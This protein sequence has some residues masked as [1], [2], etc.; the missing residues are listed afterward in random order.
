MIDVAQF[1]IDYPYFA[2][3]TKFPDVTLEGYWDIA[4]LY[5][6]DED[7]GYLTGRYRER[8]VSLMT[9]HM[10]YISES[11]NKGKQG[12]IVQSSSI[13]KISVSLVPPNIKSDFQFW[14]NQSPYGVQLLALLSAISVGGWYIPATN[15]NARGMR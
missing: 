2:N 10:G 1:R 5:V 13:D 4:T 15:M 11:A 9:A 8:A 3:V 14:L 7:Y 6:S 12:K